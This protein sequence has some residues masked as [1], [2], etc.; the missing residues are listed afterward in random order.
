MKNTKTRK[1]MTNSRSNLDISV[2]PD[3][4]EVNAG[5]ERIY[6]EYLLRSRALTK[7]V[8]KN[9]MNDVNLRGRQKLLWHLPSMQGY[10]NYRNKN[11]DNAIKKFCQIVP[12]EVVFRNIVLKQLG[13]IK[14][15][16]SPESNYFTRS[17]SNNS[18]KVP[19]NIKIELK[20]ELV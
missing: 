5:E 8:L 4:S 2:T 17:L 19:F 7:E 15:A 13:G 12:L 9:S 1:A 11:T 16:L 20:N 14:D 10:G 3:L 18:L 6:L